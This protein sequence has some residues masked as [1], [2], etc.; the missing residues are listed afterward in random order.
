MC[1]G[2]VARV[3]CVDGDSALVDIG[4]NQRSV[5]CR[6]SPGLKAGDYVM[7]HM[8]MVLGIL[9]QTQADEMVRLAREM[10]TGD[11]VRRR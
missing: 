8:G 6:F 4:G 10:R 9:D 3:L 1:L 11:D 5:D 2:T 7:I